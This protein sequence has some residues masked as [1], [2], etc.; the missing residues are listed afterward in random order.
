MKLLTGLPVGAELIVG[1]AFFRVLQ[2][3][4]GFAQFLEFRFGIRFLADIRVILARQLA[5]GALDFIL[6]GVAFHPQY[7]VV[8]FEIHLWLPLL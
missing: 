4:V 3:L 7:F 2:H 6:G 1:R 8:I 5:V